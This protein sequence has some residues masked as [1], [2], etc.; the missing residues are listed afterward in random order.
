ME[1][2]RYL[3]VDKWW[4]REV[5][6]HIPPH[7]G[8]FWLP[9]DRWYLLMRNMVCLRNN[10][11]TSR[12]A[13]WEEVGMITLSLKLLE[14]NR[15]HAK[16]HTTQSSH[17]SL[18]VTQHVR[19]DLATCVLDGC[20]KKNNKLFRNVKITWKYEHRKNIHSMNVSNK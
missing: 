19:N 18:R 5:V 3:E 8:S 2:K 11:S 20:I 1:D 7:M 6:G 17:L 13:K 9:R 15:V 14:K 4:I 12:A 16:N 10:L